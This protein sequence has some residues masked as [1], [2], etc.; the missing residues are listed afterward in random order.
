MLRD[1]R[2][3]SH[4]VF[5]VYHPSPCRRAGTRAGRD[6]DGQTRMVRNATDRRACQGDCCGFPPSASRVR[7]CRGERSI[8]VDPLKPG[9]EVRNER[10]QN[11]L[12]S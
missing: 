4:W 12:H 6:D 1:P 10:G 5:K 9:I 11:R 3:R 8:T 7:A 2:Q